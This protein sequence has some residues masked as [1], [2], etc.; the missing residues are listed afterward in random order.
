MPPASDGKVLRGELTTFASIFQSGVN[1]G[2][3][4]GLVYGFLFTW[5][6][7]ILQAL[8]MAEMAS[9]SV[10]QRKIPNAL[11][12]IPLAGGSVQLVSKSEQ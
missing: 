11:I 9:M 6:G 10:M 1:N 3:P 4:S 12:R 2:G 5:I 8:V 7:S